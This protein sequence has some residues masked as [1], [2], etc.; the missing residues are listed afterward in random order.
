MK[1]NIFNLISTLIMLLVF[2]ISG[3]FFL[4]LLCFVL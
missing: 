4:R 2:V 1:F 3:A